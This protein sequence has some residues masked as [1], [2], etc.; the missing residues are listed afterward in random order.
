[1]HSHNLYLAKY[2]VYIYFINLHD[3]FYHQTNK[4]LGFYL[5]IIKWTLNTNHFLD[6]KIFYQLSSNFIRSIFMVE[7]CI[8]HSHFFDGTQ[9]HSISAIKTQYAWFNVQTLEQ[10]NSCSIIFV[11]LDQDTLIRKVT[12]WQERGSHFPHAWN[13]FNSNPFFFFLEGT[14]NHFQAQNFLS[15]CII[16]PWHSQYYVNV[17]T[18]DSSNSSPR[19]IMFPK[20]CQIFSMSNRC[21]K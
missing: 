15:S 20:E 19:T 18:H 3:Y 12:S 6:N 13:L 10:M 1:M 14:L 17:A 16:H 8:E 11:V 7:T 4:L 5:F 9:I 21:T 2:L